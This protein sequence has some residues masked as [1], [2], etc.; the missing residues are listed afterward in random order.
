MGNEQYLMIAIMAMLLIAGCKKNSN[1]P[2]LTPSTPAN[3]IISNWEVDGLAGKENYKG[4]TINPDIKLIFPQA[5]DRN[6]VSAGISFN[7]GNYTVSYQNGDSVLML[8]PTSSLTYLSKYLLTATTTLKSKQGGI[9]FTPA[10][11]TLQTTIDSSRKFPLISDA[12]LLDKVQEQTF[13]YFW[14][15]GHPVS[16]LARERSNATPETVTSGG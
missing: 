7:E 16:G 11:F 10:T 5:I 8:Q 3:F 1:P 2:P 4:T 12:E 9:L 15:Y 6:T 14:D 13:S